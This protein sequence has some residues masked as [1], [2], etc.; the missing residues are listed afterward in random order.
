MKNTN[1][2]SRTCKINENYTEVAKI[3]FGLGLGKK[4]EEG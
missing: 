3:K 4:E 2:M 1:N